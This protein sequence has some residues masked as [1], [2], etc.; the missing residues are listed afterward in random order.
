MT[1][2][3]RLHIHLYGPGGAPLGAAFDDVV[4]R[5]CTLERLHYEPDGSLLLSGKTWQIGGLIYDR[6]EIVQ[7]VELQGTAPPQRWRSLIRTIAGPSG[8]V[9][10]LRLQDQSLHDLQAFEN[11]TWPAGDS[12]SR[13]SPG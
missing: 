10:V 8:A 7:Y 6:Q 11:S 3:P 13:P 12:A 1:R 9:S 4:R 2:F 5:V